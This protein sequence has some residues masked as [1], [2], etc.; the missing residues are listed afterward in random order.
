MLNS[1][2]VAVVCSSTNFYYC[3]T[4]N[5]NS[6]TS[7]NDSN[8]IN[9]DNNCNNDNKKIRMTIT[10]KTTVSLQINIKDITL[11]PELCI[12]LRNLNII[13]I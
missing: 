9:S 2:L 7:D 12:K 5:H 11:I 3:N 6:N 10:R 4:S 1:S 8:N 13:L